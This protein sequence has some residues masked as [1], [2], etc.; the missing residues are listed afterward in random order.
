MKQVVCVGIAVALT[1]AGQCIEVAGDRIRAGD[2]ASS[3]PE[4]SHRPPD[5]EIGMSPSPGSVRHLR[6]IELTRIL[7]SPVAGDICVV[8]LTR[9]I[10]TD[11]I[12]AAMRSSIP[13]ASVHLSV[14]DFSRSPVPPG[15]VE[16]PLSGLAQSAAPVSATPVMWR[17]RVRYDAG[18]TAAVWAR[19]QIS[20]TSRVVVARRQIRAGEALASDDVEEK[21]IDYASLTPPHSVDLDT[22][23]NSEASRDIA[24]GAIIERS[25]LR[26][27]AAVRK[28]DTIR[29]AVKSPGAELRFDAPVA[30][31]ARV[32]DRVLVRNPLNGKLVIAVVRGSGEAVID[33]GG[34]SNVQ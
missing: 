9:T 28:G 1:A 18:R 10:T 13:D 6:S 14:V 5:T 32:G 22:L 34:K 29:V 23:T 4:F 3:V 11:E 33:V 31:A 15:A 12:T 26:S 20:I 16:F 24:P 8:R 25:M 17:G 27:K 30:S 19:V 21:T 7:G 2:I